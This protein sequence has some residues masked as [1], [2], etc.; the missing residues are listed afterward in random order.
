MTILNSMNTYLP[1]TLG[2]AYQRCPSSTRF[3]RRQSFSKLSVMSVSNDAEL[4][5]GVH[6][7]SGI[8]LRTIYYELLVYYYEL[9]TMNYWYITTNYWYITTN[10]YYLICR[11]LCVMPVMYIA[12]HA[13][14]LEG[15]F[16]CNL[17]HVRFYVY[18]SCG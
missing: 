2:Q 9:F 15:Q 1:F 16:L 3:D 18:C 17:Y 11:S 4:S 10:Y 6:Y 13:D 8:S 14:V 7:I 5:P 12:V